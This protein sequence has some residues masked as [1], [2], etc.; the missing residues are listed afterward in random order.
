VRDSLLLFLAP[1]PAANRDA[2]WLPLPISSVTSTTCAGVPALALGTTLD[3]T[4]ALPDSIPLD[5][6]VRTFEV[7]QLRLYRVAPSWWLGARSVS[8][9]ETIQPVLGPLEPGGLRLA[10]FDSAGV[11]TSQADS[12]RSV[13]VTLV[14]LSARAVRHNSDAPLSLLRDSAGGW[15]PLRNLQ[16]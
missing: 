14:G 7:M 12:V 9:G 13:R 6:P 8:G 1:D 3:S 10:Y 4:F 2:R 11:P 5:A 15:L 16:P